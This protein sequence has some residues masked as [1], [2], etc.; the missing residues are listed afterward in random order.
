MKAIR[1]IAHLWR[2]RSISSALWV[3]QYEKHE[4]K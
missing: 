3:M 1:F 4:K 2:L